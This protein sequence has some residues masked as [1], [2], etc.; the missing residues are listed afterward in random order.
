[1]T[2]ENK[3]VVERFYREVV[4]QK[5]L[6]ILHEVMAE[7]YTEHGNPDGS[8]IEGFKRF[9]QGLSAA[10]PDL[11]ITVEDLIAEADKVVARVTVEATHA[12]VFMG[13]VEPTGRHVTFS[14]VDVFHIEDGKIVGRWNLRD[15]LGL[16]RQLGVTT[17]P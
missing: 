9:V 13:S 15:L 16:L 12:G 2:I 17:L 1:M 5:D 10:F 4:N 11:T 6:D 7:D 14:G 3:A 8:G